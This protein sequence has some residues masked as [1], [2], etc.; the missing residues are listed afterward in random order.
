MAI[1]VY[2]NKVDFPPILGP[3]TNNVLAGS[4]NVLIWVELEIKFYLIHG[5]IISISWM[6]GLH[7]I[8]PFS[9]KSSMISGQQLFLLR[10]LADASDYKQSNS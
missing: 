4:V 3:V 8:F 5:C 9:S 7:L 10:L 6:N 2:L 1:H